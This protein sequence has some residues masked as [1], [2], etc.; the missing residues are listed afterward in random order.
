MEHNIIDCA[1]IDGPREF[2][3]ILAKK[4]SFS[5]WNGC[6]L[7]ALHDCLT[8]ISRETAMT[9][10]RRNSMGAFAAGF[11]RC[12][13]DAARENPCLSITFQ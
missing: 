3:H 11:R 5:G 1:K 8:S 4:L 13:I 9:F 6:N 2:H 7:D 12:L 10:Q